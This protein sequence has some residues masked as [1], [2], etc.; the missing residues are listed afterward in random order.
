MRVNFFLYKN[1][2]SP[3]R[4][5]SSMRIEIYVLALKK[6]IPEYGNIKHT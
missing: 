5:F 4:K 1:Y 2:F 3:K 6:I